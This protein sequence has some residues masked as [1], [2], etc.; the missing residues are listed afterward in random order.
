MSDRSDFVP[1]KSRVIGCPL[2]GALGDAWGGPWEG[3]IGPVPFEVPSHPVLSDD[4]QLT[5][6]TC[7]SIIETDAVQPERV[8]TRFAM[9]FRSGRIRGMGS[10]TLK[11]MRDLAAGT[12]WA[13][14]G[15]RGEYSA[16]NGA[17]M[18]IAP[19]AFI[20]NPADPDD[21]ITISD[22]CRITHHNDE[23]YV[24]ALAVMFAIRAAMSGTYMERTTLLGSIAGELPD[25]SVRDRILQFLELRIPPTE[26]AQRFGATGHVVDSVPLALYCAYDVHCVGLELVLAR[27][28]GM[29]GDTDTIA[30]ITG[31]IAGAFVGIEGVPQSLLVNVEG[32]QEVRAVANAFADFVEKRNA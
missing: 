20:L 6:A 23:A 29:G 17:A 22:V 18:R 3:R 15:A 4:T 14:A 32:A 21:R 1:L 10:S 26:V 13:L 9:W 11:A 28:I 31:Q 25:S 7:E 16:G 12:H 19:L 2:A 5:L 24:G 30:S 8:A 27:T